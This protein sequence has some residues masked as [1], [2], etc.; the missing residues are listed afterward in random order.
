[1]WG[2][3]T[4][5]TYKIT[6]GN[7]LEDY[8]SAHHGYIGNITKIQTTETGSMF[9]YFLPC[10]DSFYGV[11]RQHHLFYTKLK[12]KVQTMFCL[13]FAMFVPGEQLADRLVELSSISQIDS[14][15]SPGSCGDRFSKKCYHQ[16]PRKLSTYKKNLSRPNTDREL[17]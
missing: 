2:K 4:E 11:E 8:I 15:S 14:G 16:R 17:K 10:L 9:A 7:H 1:M 13:L 3:N 6:Y 5:E 12:G